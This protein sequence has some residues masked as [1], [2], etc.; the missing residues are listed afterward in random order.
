VKGV[1]LAG[2]MGT[3]LYPITVA[4]SKQLLPVYDK[5]LIYYPLSTLMLAGIRDILV[6]TTPHAKPQF[7]YLLG[8]GSQWGISLS[9]AIQDEPRG[10][11][12][13]LIVGSDF[14][15]GQRVA[16]ILG[17]NLFHGHGLIDLLQH[18]SARS[19]G[20]TVFACRVREPQHYGVVEFDTHGCA[21]SIEEKPRYPR[22]NW[23]VTGLYFYDSRAV[24]LAVELEPSKRG[25]LEI[26]E[27]NRLYMDM[28]ALRVE[29]LGR[30]IT[31]LDTG[32]PDSLLAASEFVRTIEE[33][34]GKKIACPEEVAYSMGYIGPEEMRAIG[35]RLK[36]NSYGRYLLE[37][38]ENDKPTNSS[39]VANLHTRQHPP[40]K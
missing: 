10:L 35:D 14:I 8:D 22:S 5:P 12:D 7:E 32:T 6:I 18:A 40:W 20:A 16:L 9:Y 26:T 13:A 15:D 11:A 27:L 39:K 34:Q 33:R 25:E 19:Q 31:W 30:G 17:D 1:I 23:A 3:R 4:V 36:N 29:R 2:G 38:L 28:H 21:T 37:L 24:E